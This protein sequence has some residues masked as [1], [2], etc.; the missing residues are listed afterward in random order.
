MKA[1]DLIREKI[2]GGE[3]DREKLL[4][5][6]MKVCG[7]SR[8]YAG[9]AYRRVTG[10]LVRPRVNTK[11]RKNNSSLKTVD[12]DALVNRERLDP[13]RIVREGLKHVG[14]NVVDDDVF[15]RFLELS[16]MVWA[17]VRNLEEFRECQVVLPSKKRVWAME[18]TR[19]YLL[20]LDGV[21]ELDH[22]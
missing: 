16:T 18:G 8:D 4:R 19:D 13:A 7:V 12:V 15:R 6:A 9:A 1:T 10:E 14:E 21:R 5:A 22:G 17:D 3:T 2:E 11:G 20:S